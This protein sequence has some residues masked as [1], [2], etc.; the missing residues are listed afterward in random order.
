LFQIAS[1]SSYPLRLALIFHETRRRMGKAV[2][3]T[4]GDPVSS[5]A[6]RALER[7]HVA[8]TLRRRCMALAAH[9]AVDPDEVFIWPPHLR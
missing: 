7:G 6:L 8:E 4:V 5:A 2:H 3:L 9:G 1:H